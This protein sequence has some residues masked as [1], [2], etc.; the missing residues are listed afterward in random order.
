ML[1]DFRE[2]GRERKEESDIDRF[3]PV[4]APT[5]DQICNPGMCPDQELNLWPFSLWD[6]T[7]I[8]WT[9]RLG[10]SYHIFIVIQTEVCRAVY[11]YMEIIIQNLFSNFAIYNRF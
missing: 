7:S 10:P 4:H 11:N 8:N 5:R 1:I 2:R 9:T 6:N 3:P